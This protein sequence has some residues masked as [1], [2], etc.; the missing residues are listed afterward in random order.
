MAAQRQVPAQVSFA[1]GL[2]S[3]R[4][5]EGRLEV[6]KGELLQ[7]IH[8]WAGTT[9][10]WL[11]QFTELLPEE[12]LREHALRVLAA[13]NFQGPR[14]EDA[15]VSMNSHGLKEFSPNRQTD[16]SMEMARKY[17]A[18][19]WRG[20]SQELYEADPN[21]LHHPRNPQSLHQT[22]EWETFLK[23][24]MNGTFRPYVFPALLWKIPGPPETSP[25]P[26]SQPLNCL[27]LPIIITSKGGT[28]RHWGMV[29]EVWIA[30]SVYQKGWGLRHLQLVK[31]SSACMTVFAQESGRVLH[32][33]PASMT[34]YGNHGDYNLALANDFTGPD[35][36]GGQCTASRQVQEEAGKEEA[37]KSFLELLLMGSPDLLQRLRSLHLSELFCSRIEI[38]ST[39][40]K[41]WMRLEAGQESHQDIQVTGAV[42]PVTLERILIISQLDVTDIVLAQ[43]EVMKANH[44]LALEKERMQALLQ[45]QYDLIQ[46][47]RDSSPAVGNDSRDSSSGRLVPTKGGIDLHGEINSIREILSAA[48]ASKPTRADE[49]HLHHMIGQ[50]ATGTVYRGE[51]RGTVVAVKRMVLPSA[52]SNSERAQKMAVMEIAISSSLQ[53]PHLVQTYTYSTKPQWDEPMQV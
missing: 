22:Q 29:R 16:E 5:S 35:A 37:G 11:Y 50:G 15:F 1:E 10:L 27:C 4:L 53:H 28:R 20:G 17:L 38:V 52:M 23:N 49:I 7:L 31:N 3:Y 19:W 45:R 18:S 47:L 46:V 30:D 48:G 24:V 36:R 8:E 12:N 9:S 43:K 40:I 34:L 33:N 25:R 14:D 44:E 39:R 32:Q 13:G 6:D 2:C 26:E 42:D 51:W 41:D 21:S